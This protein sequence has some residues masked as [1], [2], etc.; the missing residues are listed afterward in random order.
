MIKYR[1]VFR[2]GAF[3]TFLIISLLVLIFAVVIQNVWLYL[4]LQILIFIMS[5]EF[6]EVDI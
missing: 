4:V 6:E 1:F 3:R 2:G 5:V